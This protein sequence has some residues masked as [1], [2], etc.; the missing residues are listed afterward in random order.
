MDE[1]RAVVQR[2]NA[3]KTQGRT[4]LSLGPFAAPSLNGV[5]DLALILR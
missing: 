2:K 3:V 5:S 4:F 1:D